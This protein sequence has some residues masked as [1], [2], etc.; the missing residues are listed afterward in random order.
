MLTITRKDKGN[1]WG[2]R[3]SKLTKTNSFDQFV[4][5]NKCNFFDKKKE[6]IILFQSIEKF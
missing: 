2:K 5:I 6:K 3:K 1:K 4:K